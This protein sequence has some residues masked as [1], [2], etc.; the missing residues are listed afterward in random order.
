MNHQARAEARVEYRFAVNGHH[1]NGTDKLSG[2]GVRKF[3]KALFS[4]GGGVPGKELL[5]A[6]R[7]AI[8][9]YYDRQNPSR[10]TASLPEPFYYWFGL[11]FGL[12][13]CLFPKLWGD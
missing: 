3:D 1:Y 12:V 2:D 7:P 5:L 13:L 8:T 11:A 9:V 4:A 6:P 10:N